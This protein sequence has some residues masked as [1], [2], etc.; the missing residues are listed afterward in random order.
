MADIFAEAKRH[1]MDR[2]AATPVALQPFAHVV[3]EN[4]FPDA[5]YGELRRHLLPTGS[6][7]Q[8]ASTGRVSKAYN[9]A[10]H[11][12]MAEDLDKAGAEP[13]A[14]DFWKNLFAAYCDDAFT[15][16]WLNRFEPQLVERMRSGDVPFPRT[17]APVN[18]RREMLLMRD[19][20]GYDLP[21]HTDSPSKVVS[22]LFYLPGDDGHPDTGTALYR[23]KDRDFSHPGGPYLSR[24][25]FD[26]VKVLPFRRNT[27]VAFPKSSICFHGVEPVADPDLR[28]DILL[29][30]IRFAL[31]TPAP[32]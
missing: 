14:R 25:D 16:L 32:A 23:A 1:S 19:G 26:L 18:L 12:L 2:I 3:V 10:R 5:F 9:P 27:L 21:P 13:E 6:Y 8:L 28:R 29:F 30:D 4:I 7:R 22:V 20:A 15:N 24:E 17:D 11:V 31:D